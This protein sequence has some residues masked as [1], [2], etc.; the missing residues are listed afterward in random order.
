MPSPGVSQNKQPP[1]SINSSS[2]LGNVE[3]GE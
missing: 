2:T 1:L 3:Q